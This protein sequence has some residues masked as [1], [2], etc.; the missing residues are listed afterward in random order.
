MHI[1]TS[2]KFV[3][4]GFSNAVNDTKTQGITIR[5]N[6]TSHAYVFCDAL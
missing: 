5:M 1:E 6:R 2:R 3:T 4:A